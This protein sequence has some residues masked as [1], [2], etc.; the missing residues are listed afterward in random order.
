MKN[1][2]KIPPRVTKY[3]M[4]VLLTVYS[5]LNSIAQV[6]PSERQALIDLYTA[7]VGTNWTN[8]QANNKPWFINDSNSLVQDWHGVTVVANKV[9]G[10]TLDNNNLVGTIPNS[11]S[12]L[13]NLETLS[14]SKNT[15]SGS[16]PDTIGG[17]VNLKTL[18]LERNKLTGSIPVTISNL[19]NLTNLSLYLNKLD[20]IIPSELGSLT[21]LKVIHIGFNNFQGSIPVSLGNL[22]KLTYLYI[23]N[24]KL[25]GTIP[26][27]LGNLIN[28]V[29]LGVSNNNLSGN[30]PNEISNLTKLA[31]FSFE[32]NDF[33]FTDFESKH[34]YYKSKFRTYRYF[35]QGKVDIE[36]TLSIEG[37]QSI[38]LTSS[39]LT[40][41]NNTYQWYKNTTPIAGATNKNLVISNA[42]DA[43]AG[44]YYFI[45]NNT[46][47]TDLSLERNSITISVASSPVDDIV[48]VSEA[49]RQA[50]IDLYI[51]TAGASWTNTQANNQP[52]LINDPNSFIKDWYGVTVVDNKVTGLQLDNNNLVGTIPNSISNLFNLESLSLIRNTLSG[53]IPSTIGD[54][55]NL[56]VVSLERNTLTGSIP[57]TISNLSKLTNISLFLN[58]LSGVIPSGLGNLTEL[59]SIHIGHNKLQGS[60]P[61]SFGNLSKLTNLYVSDNNLEGA[62]P[63]EL[64]NLTSIVSLSISYNNFSG[65]IPSQISNLTGLINFRFEGNSFVFKDFETEHFASKSKLV[66]YIYSPQDKVDQEKD[67]SVPL[68]QSITLSSTALTST[69]NNYQWYKNNVAI[70]GAT[71]K[72]LVISNTTDTDAGVY[73]YTATNTVVTDL[74]LT[75]NPI[76]LSISAADACGVSAAEKQALIDLYNGTNGANWSNNT[77]WLSATIPV[78]DWYGVTVV[79]GKVTAIELV[80]NNLVG[81]IPLGIKGLTNLV[82]LNLETNQLTGTIPIELGQLTNLQFL[83]LNQNDLYGGIPTELELLN[84]LTS[85]YLGHNKLTGAIPVSLTKLSNLRY[86]HL[87]GNKLSGVI[88]VALGTLS[89]LT[90]LNLYS[91]ALTGNIPAEL[92]QLLNL[93]SLHLDNNQLT[94]SIPVTFGEL[95]N[96]VD[97]NLYNNSLSGSIPAVLGNLSNLQ[98]LYIYNNQLSGTIPVTF[99]QLSNLKT[100]DVHSNELTGE[101]PNTLSKLLNLESLWVHDNQFSGKIPSTLVTLPK[102]QLL[103]LN[104]NQFVFS[105][106]ESEFNAYVSRFGSGFKYFPQG[107]VDLEEEQPVVIGDEIILRTRVL[108][109]SNNSYQWFKNNVAILGATNSTLK[110]TAAKESDAGVYHFEATNS[111]VYNLNLVRNPITLKVTSDV[112]SV[113]AIEKQALIDFYTQTGGESW[114]TKTNWLTD[115]PVCNWYGVTVVN[116]K[117]TGL[118][119]SNNNLSGTIPFSVFQLFNL[120]HIDLSNNQLIGEIPNEFKRLIEIEE[121]LLFNNQLQGGVSKVFGQLIKLKRILLNNNQ[122]I[123]NI[124]VEL[125]QISGLT[126]LKLNDNQ[127]SGDIPLGFDQLTGLTNF[128]LFNNQ[129]VFS[130]IEA[131]FI[132]LQTKLGT[133]FVYQPQEKVDQNEIISVAIG[134][135]VTLTSIDLTSV[136][137][138][139]QWYKD[140]EAVPGA[141][142]KN[143]VIMSPSSMDAGVYHFTSSNSVVSDL[144]LTRNPITLEVGTVSCEISATERQA[145]IDIYNNTNGANWANTLVNNKSW[146]INDPNSKVCDWYGVKVTN[147]K[148]SSLRLMNNNLA[149]NIPSSL[150]KLSG[151]EEIQLS[152]NQLVGV[153]P[154]EL[155]KLSKLQTLNLEN[156]NLEG[157]ILENIGQLSNL[158]HLLLSNNNLT[159]SIPETLGQII[160]LQDL[161]LATN[162]LTGTIPEG[163]GGLSNLRSVILSNNQLS[164]TVPA[165]F[166]QLTKLEELRINNNQL[167][168][169]IPSGFDQL[170]GFR[171]FTIFDNKFIFSEIEPTFT[172]LKAKLGVGFIHDPQAKVD[173]IE[174]KTIVTGLQEILTS[175]TLISTN[176]S[177]QWY[178]DGV[179]IPGAT[180]KELI[181]N[182]VSNN[183]IGVYHFV[184]TNSVVTEL[185]IERNPI[186]ISVAPSDSCGVSA[187]EKQGLIDFYTTT[188][189]ARWI[190]NTNWL[191]TTVPVCDWYGVTV[192]DGKVTALSLP[193]NNITGRIPASISQLV[194]LTTLRLNDNKLS[195][196]IPSTLGKVV[197]LEHLYLSWNHLTGEIPSDLGKLKGLK[198]LEAMGNQLTGNIP[199]ELGSLTSLERLSLYRNLLT[200]R[201][202]VELSSLL[203]LRYLSLSDNQLSESIPASLGNLP[204]LEEL[205]LFRNQLTEGIPV[206]LGQ[207]SSLK[208]LYLNHNQLSG[209]IPAEFGALSNLQYLWLSTNELTNNIPTEL[210]NLRKLQDFKANDNQLSGSIP[211][212][213]GNV[214]SL[215]YLELARNQLS[216]PIPVQFGQLTNLEQL[217]LSDNQLSG[218]VP[219]VLSQLTSLK[220]LMID[221]NRFVFWNVEPEFN[222]YKSN[223]TSFLYAPQAK[224]DNVEN[225]TIYTGKS[226]TFTSNALTSTNNSY[227]WYKNNT[228][229][230]GATNKDL[231]ITNATTTDAGVYHFTATNGVVTALT[232]VR[233]SITLSVLV[234]NWESTQSF[235]SSEKIPTVSD[236]V[237]PIPNIPTVT[238]YETQTGGT[239]L[240]GSTELEPIVYWAE[241]NDNNPRVGVKVN[242]NEGAPGTNEEDYQVFSIV[243][244]AKIKDLKITGTN[245]TWY[246]V[247]T[248]GIPLDINSILE[249]GKSYYAQQGAVS[250]RFE[251]VVAVKVFEP[252]GDTWQAFCK[253]DDPTINDLT[254]RFIILGSDTLIWY[255]N[256]SGSEVYSS[257]EGIVNKGVYYVSQRDALNNESS[258][259]RVTV[260][261]YDIP[262]PVVTRKNQTFYTND[263]VY[264]SDLV[265]FG[266][267]ILWYDKAFGGIAYNPTEQLV[268][269]ATYYAGQTSYN[270]TAGETGCCISTLREEVTVRILEKPLPSLVGCELFR[271][272]PGE[273]YVISAWVREDGL[274]AINP[275]TR[276][277]SE[278]SSVFTKLLNHLVKD[279]IFAPMIKDRHIPE[280]Y[281]PKPESREFDVLIPFIKDATDKNLTIYNFK[282]VKEKQDGIGPERTVGFEFS[283]IPGSNAFKFRYITPRVKRRR[284]TYNYHYP[285]LKNPTL[286]LNFKETS[287]CGANFCMTSYFKIEGGNLGREVTETIPSTNDSPLSSAITSYTYI[288]DPNYQAMEYANSLLWLRFRDE[289]GL[290][291]VPQNSTDIEFKPKGAVIDGWQRISAEF[292]IPIEATNMQIRLESRIKPDGPQEL[293]VYFDDIRMHRFDGNMKTFVY[294]PVTQ[295]LKSELDENNYATFYEYDQEG[296][297]IRVKKETERGV[298]TIQETR[299]GNSKLNNAQK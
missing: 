95:I 24:N 143:F 157:G 54:L 15:I 260:T 277:F 219:T 227:Q 144:T 12:N 112:C 241:G 81:D 50:L 248:G 290:D 57:A 92:G 291:I 207:L 20:G 285:L 262:A 96:L 222:T 200:G 30:I 215:K 22:S 19:S 187:A 36:E 11:I 66:N 52:W 129:F 194:N 53:D 42:T 102:L 287:V 271:P 37:G 127:L 163:L 191:S 213:L 113:S 79:D 55:V 71:S 247:S 25:E 228:A 41:I 160:K 235:C 264:I 34:A 28:L 284:T 147:G 78:C 85:L 211:T 210:G 279:K 18:S 124:P 99:G 126:E 182:D 197:S 109:S 196:D 76:T 236:L 202:P 32:N 73:N 250:C 154:L 217:Y 105:N 56:K 252:N 225:Y 128:S 198:T 186:T 33:V 288:P 100:L 23:S 14:L 257:T 90:D 237:S 148:V 295:R 294:D 64:G 80:S 296:G 220:H 208:H 120:K 269:G 60:I 108:T 249:N 10:L 272:Q 44:V 203:N 1:L 106:L 193:K 118:K 43:D 170:V 240:V 214:L 233:N 132:A 110:I 180:N 292:T 93:K 104:D 246:G 111:I 251:V 62:I 234:P 256:A 119:L 161:Q 9:T 145:L 183:D 176:N 130:Q 223:L 31:S 299:S 158:E 136:N 283:L 280:V 155:L 156:N 274:Q 123:G 185:I 253:S 88:P 58:K 232:L 298:F 239:A 103:Y 114:T 121:V 165:I 40:S 261:V 168:G 26:S 263:P 243:S 61:S 38:T 171:N 46:I 212:V 77:N 254:K 218:R 98:S 4:L 13:V 8:T 68:G 231:I 17:L 189:G 135:P 273:K 35:P 267:N 188:N 159:G 173:E 238:W 116:G 268:D 201:I 2:T 59:K 276:N 167:S 133:G 221:S 149:G 278:V 72:D 205:S 97:L 150:F 89:N 63:Q 230:P 169:S 281:I 137:N 75:S 286:V 86:L 138:S 16:I 293:N 141:T 7:T 244:N 229:I 65:K 74:T 184:A 275:V 190:N 195:G 166:T 162:Q 172:I 122:L 69:N 6:S 83:S 164:G 258:R 115:I 146:D 181:L 297:L 175:K 117:V 87:Q 226:I 67:L 209:S 140:N 242:I 82:K 178:K 224:V 204:K 192:V 177:Y 91:N 125:T 27:Q 289:S 134:E 101:L 48:K 29:T 255:R 245:I 139:Y 47:V 179:A 21:E 45:A 206:Q 94:G 265:A 266:N 84:K 70:T 51:A 153:I 5:G 49:E 142:G 151:L 259:K 174:S 3:F 199:V 152:S 216:G 107:K 131:S 39:H 282:Y 270:C